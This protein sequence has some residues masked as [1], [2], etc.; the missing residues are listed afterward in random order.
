[1]V[2]ILNAFL[3][4]FYNQKVTYDFSRLNNPK[5]PGSN[6]GPATN[7]FQGARI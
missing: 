4:P 6:P 1:M 2:Q 5:V 7:Q 3:I